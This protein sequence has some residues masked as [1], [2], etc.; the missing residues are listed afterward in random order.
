MRHGYDAFA[1][2][3][4]SAGTSAKNGEWCQACTCFTNNRNGRSPDGVAATPLTQYRPTVVS[5]GTS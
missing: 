1:I 2:S 5:E 4:I 3:W